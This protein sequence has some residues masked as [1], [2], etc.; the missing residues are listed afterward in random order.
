[1]DVGSVDLDA[2]ALETLR[3]TFAMRP[4]A[5]WSPSGVCVPWWERV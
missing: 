1:M 4:R 3:P 5:G 2:A